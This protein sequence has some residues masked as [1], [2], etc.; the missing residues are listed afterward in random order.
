M[1]AT[2]GEAVGATSGEAVGA[3]TGEAVG[4]VLESRNPCARRAPNSSM[5]VRAS[6][7]DDG[8]S[9]GEAGASA[10]SGSSSWNEGGPEARASAARPSLSVSGVPSA[11]PSPNIQRDAKSDIPSGAK[12]GA[13]AEAGARES[14]RAMRPSVRA[15]ALG[16]PGREPGARRSTAREQAAREPERAGEQSARGC[17]GLLRHQVVWAVP[18]VSASSEEAAPVGVLEVEDRLERPV[19]VVGELGP[20]PRTA[21]AET[22]ASFPQA[23]VLD[24]GEVDLERVRCTPGSVTCP[25]ELAVGVEPLVEALQ[26]VEVG[27]E[28]VLDD[29]RA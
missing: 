24:L 22:A 28:Q 20:S 16:H 21:H 18:S 2:S 29:R 26:V 8:T 6:A 1:G 10:D 15:P 11:R 5:G 9:T 19:E 13:A 27:G 4:A 14:R 12:T 25:T 23:A 7:A 17:G 3:A